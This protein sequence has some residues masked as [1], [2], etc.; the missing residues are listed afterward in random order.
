M[1]TI[2]FYELPEK[3]KNITF[4]GDKEDL[5]LHSNNSFYWGRKTKKAYKEVDKQL[6]AF[7]IRGNGWSIYTWCDVSGFEYWMKN[8]QEYNYVQIS[9]IF[10]T[11]DVLL[12]EVKNI[13]QGLFEAECFAQEIED[14]NN[15]EFNY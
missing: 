14:G 7:K 8:Q 6:D 1:K 12:S 5:R 15:I 3:I 13:E 4:D 9:I 10:D 2:K 11:E